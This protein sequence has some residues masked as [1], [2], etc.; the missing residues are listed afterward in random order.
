LEYLKTHP[1]NRS[2]DG[3]RLSDLYY[4]DKLFGVNTLVYTLEQCGPSQ[5]PIATLLHRPAKVLSKAETE[6]AMKLNLFEDHFSYIKDMKKYSKSFTC[7]RCGKVFQKDCKLMRHERTCE[8]KVKLDYP[9]GVYTP[10]KTVFEKLEEEGVEV[11]Q[12]LKYSKYFGT[13]D[14]EVFYPKSNTLPAK[15][16]KL[17]FTAEYT[18]LSVSVTANVPGYLEPKCLIVGGDQREDGEELVKELVTYLNKISD[19]AYE[20]EQARYA[21]L[22]ATIRERLR[23]DP[24]ADDDDDIVDEVGFDGE[25]GEEEGEGE[26][27]TNSDREFIDDDIEEE[28]VLSIDVWIWSD[29]ENPP[30]P[31][32]QVHLQ[33]LQKNL[34]ESRRKLNG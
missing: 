30:Q 29:K 34:P 20:L 2:E 4:L 3:V 9:G 19:A 1:K 33:L 5:K 28:D 16:P 8:A 21:E 26:V 10:S 23:A 25:S 15:R 18:L 11:P 24:E 7:E 31:L 32:H 12:D 13:F 14:I 22:R 6:Q 17:E 27:E